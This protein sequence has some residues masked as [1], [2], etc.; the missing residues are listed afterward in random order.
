M[1]WDLVYTK[2]WKN[3]E[4][5]LILFN[6]GID[7]FRS[8]PFCSFYLYTE[9]EELSSMKFHLGTFIRKVL[10]TRFLVFK[11]NPEQKIGNFQS[12]FSHFTIKTCTKFAEKRQLAEEKDP[13]VIRVLQIDAYVHQ[14]IRDCSR[15][16]F[17]CSRTN[18]TCSSKFSFRFE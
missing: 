7:G 13:Y 6:S 14:E 17:N 3:G 5:A 16:Q 9:L 12:K 15:T 10:V 4:W 18:T 1:I 11:R 8:S 2:Y